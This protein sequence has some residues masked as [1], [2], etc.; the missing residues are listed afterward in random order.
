M[1]RITGLFPHALA[2]AKEGYSA[3]EFYN[4][5][6]EAGE[7]PRS[8]DAYKL[9]GIAKSAVEKMKDE[10]FANQKAVPSSSELSDW[11]VK[12]GTGISQRILITY[13]DRATG[14]YVS[15]WYT[16]KSETGVTREAATATA[17]RAYEDKAENYGQDLIAAVHMAAYL[18]VPFQ[19]T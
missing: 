15:T 7:A 12:V 5:L 16:V 1:A 17:I 14:T 9:F 8:S 4:M 3:T 6:K 11:P 18:L 13:K 2:A 19:A 10:P